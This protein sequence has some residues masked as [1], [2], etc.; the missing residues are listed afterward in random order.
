MMNLPRLLLG[1]VR[2]HHVYA[3]PLDTFDAA[4]HGATVKDTEAKYA[5]EMDC[6]EFGRVKCKPATKRGRAC[7]HNAAVRRHLARD[8]GTR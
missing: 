2:V 8:R 7:L 4:L 5:A 1:A 6:G 3:R